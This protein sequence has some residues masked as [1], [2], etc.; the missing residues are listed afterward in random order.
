MEKQVV[1]YKPYNERTPDNQYHK[2]LTD[3]LAD[4]DVKTSF[5]AKAKENDGSG[6]K[7]CLELP[8]RE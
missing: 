1:M 7:Y 2:L 4:G 5:H 8:K 3:I 6:H